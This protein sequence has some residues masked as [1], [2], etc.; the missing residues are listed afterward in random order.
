M[1]FIIGRLMDK[2]VSR[3]EELGNKRLRKEEQ[4]KRSVINTVV[5]SWHNIGYVTANPISNG[6]ASI[7]SVIQASIRSNRNRADNERSKPAHHHNGNN[8]LL[9]ATIQVPYGLEIKSLVCNEY[10]YESE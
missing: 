3:V 6:L 9:T 8:K 1:A 4:H 2:S 7:P 10:G 5:N